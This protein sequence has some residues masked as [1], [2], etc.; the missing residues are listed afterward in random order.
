MLRDKHRHLGINVV[1]LGYVGYKVPLYPYFLKFVSSYQTM[2]TITPSSSF[3]H[4]QNCQWLNA[5]KTPKLMKLLLK[6]N[7]IFHYF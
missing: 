3:A 4:A 2:S 5:S 6:L 7:T 1:F